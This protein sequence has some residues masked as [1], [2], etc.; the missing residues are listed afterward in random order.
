MNAEER[1]ERLMEGLLAQLKYNCPYPIQMAGQHQVLFTCDV[2]LA[3]KMIV[4]LINGKPQSDYI[5]LKNNQILFSC[6]NCGRQILGTFPNIKRPVKKSSPVEEKQKDDD[7][8]AL[9]VSVSDSVKSRDRV[10]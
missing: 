10:G 6:R 5:L 4:L 9:G 1:E 8:P 2:C 7:P 3:Q